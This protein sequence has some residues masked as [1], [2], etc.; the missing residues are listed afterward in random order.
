MRVLALS[1]GR[2]PVRRQW[3]WP[4]DAV[5]QRRFGLEHLISIAVINSQTMR[6]WNRYFRDENQATDVLA[7]QLKS[8]PGVGGPSELWGEVLICWPRVKRQ[9]GAPGHSTGPGV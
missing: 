8:A 6:R 5:L 3:L 2:Y 1:P 4:L 7:F 9:G